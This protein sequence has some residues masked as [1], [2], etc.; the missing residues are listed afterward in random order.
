[1][2]RILQTES[3]QWVSVYEGGTV[4]GREGLKEGCGEAGRG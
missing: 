2:G 4:G 1:M 3:G